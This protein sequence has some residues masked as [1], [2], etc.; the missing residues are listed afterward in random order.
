MICTARIASA[1]LIGRI[2]TTSGRGTRRRARTELVRYIGTLRPQRDVADF[3]AVLDQ[4]LLEGERAADGEATSRR[5]R[6]PDVG[7]FLDQFT[8]RQ[9]R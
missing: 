5:A 2:D 4:R 6:R 7:R 3:D 1:G 8:V 9:T